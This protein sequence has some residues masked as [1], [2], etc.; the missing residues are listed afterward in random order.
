[1]SN[2]ILTCLGKII[3]GGLPVGAYGGKKEIMQMI[4]PSGECISSWY[5]KW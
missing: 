4:A 3:G 5:I 2:Q 1:M